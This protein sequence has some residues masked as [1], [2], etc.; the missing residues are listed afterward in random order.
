MW[1]RSD[2]LRAS[3]LYIPWQEAGTYGV[4]KLD[5]P[6][7]LEYLEQHKLIVVGWIQALPTK[8]A[9]LSVAAQHTQ[10]LIQNNVRN[11]VAIMVDHQKELHDICIY[12]HLCIYFYIHPYIYIYTCV[13]VHMY[14][15][16]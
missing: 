12:F 13:A 1:R 3:A 15:K 4:A 10:Y 14:I 11:A 8:S 5:D 7:I 16:Q 2:I 6:K 9:C